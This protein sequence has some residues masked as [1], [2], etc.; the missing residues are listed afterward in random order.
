MPTYIALLQAVNVSGVGRILT[1]DLRG[2]CVQA[3]YDEVRTYIASGNVVFARADTAAKMI[4]R[5]P[6]QADAGVHSKLRRNACR[7]NRKPV[8]LRVACMQLGV[9][10]GRQA[11]A[12]C[13]DER[14]PR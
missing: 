11:S 6:R 4:E 3:G 5:S 8:S 14:A 1:A 12:G 2:P 13:V 10:S 7:A 9:F